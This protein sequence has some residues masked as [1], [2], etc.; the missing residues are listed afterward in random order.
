MNLTTLVQGTAKSVPPLTKPVINSMKNNI[1]NFLL[2][3]KTI[4]YIFMINCLLN[5][6][7]LFIFYEVPENFPLSYNQ[8]LM[9]SI[10]NSLVYALFAYL[11]LKKIKIFEWLMVLL[12]FLTGVHSTLLGIFRV[13]LHQFIVKPFFIEISLFYA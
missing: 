10:L 7:W 12:L 2:S 5:I 1:V 11:A 8:A 6:I 4:L 3:P 9:L 13:E